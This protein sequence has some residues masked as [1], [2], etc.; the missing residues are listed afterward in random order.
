MRILH[1]SSSQTRPS[2]EGFFAEKQSGIEVMDLVFHFAREGEDPQYHIV[3]KGPQVVIEGVKASFE[4]EYDQKFRNICD[5]LLKELNPDVVHVHVS[6]GLSLLPV[7]NVASSL[8]MKK[9]ITLHDQSLI[10]PNKGTPEG[11]TK[12]ASRVLS[13]KS[14]SL[15]KKLKCA[16]DQSHLVIC[17]SKAQR[18]LLG[19]LFKKRKRII[20]D[21]L[22]PQDLMQAC[23][24]IHKKD[25][26]NLFFKVGHMCN[27]ACLYCVAGEP[28]H[29]PFIDL[30]VIKKE[31]EEKAALYDCIIFTGGEPSMHPRF[32]ELLSIVYY[33]GYKIEIQSNIRMFSSKRFTER[34]RK[35]NVRL[36]VCMNSSRDDVFDRM[37][38]AKGAFKQTVLGARNIINAGI[39][40]DSKVIITTYNYDHLTE[41]VEFVQSFGITSIMLVFPTPM[42][43]SK[44]N[45]KEI[46]PRY[47]DIMPAV[48]KALQW[49]LDRNLCMETENIPGCILHENYHRCNSE[50][51]NQQNL[52]GIYMNFPKGL[53]NCKTERVTAQK[54]KVTGCANCQYSSKCEG[55]YREYVS[56][57]GEEEFNPATTRV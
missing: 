45:F 24:K 56:H 9:V 17:P 10:F 48:H 34:I 25:G 1:I 22:T 18:E 49:G 52:D 12:I 36:I 33:L 44:D 43:L 16:L 50:Y 41:I 20:T 4:H 35:Y 26:R 55:V 14:N 57:F 38:N 46:N 28:N 27:S 30:K 47:S 42:G 6:A 21:G 54:M 8:R 2:I 53:Y 51:K 19:A 39:E 11:H 29:E 40:L 3:K 7:L 15:Y 37:A 32:F 23:E 13:D 5:Q 31:L